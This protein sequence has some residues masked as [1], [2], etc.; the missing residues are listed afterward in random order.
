MKQKKTDQEITENIVLRC[1]ENA[2]KRYYKLAQ[3]MAEEY[4]T[5]ECPKCKQ[6]SAV[7]KCLTKNKKFY[8]CP[9]RLCKEK[10]CV[11]CRSPEEIHKDATCDQAMKIGANP[12][13][14]IICPNCKS[15]N[16]HENDAFGIFFCY[17]LFEFFSFIHRV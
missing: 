4:I 3:E 1:E 17:C 12:K 2:Q 9:N 5:F 6:E 10:Y 16:E 13:L 8:Q 11:D 14:C 15:W 7:D